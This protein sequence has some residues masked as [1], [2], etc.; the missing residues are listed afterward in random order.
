MADTAFGI[1]PT[2]RWTTGGPGGACQRRS[3]TGSGT[4]SVMDP[5]GQGVGE[6][7][8]HDPSVLILIW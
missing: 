6:V 3:K 8:D 1:E 7:V 4:L 5:G 2:S